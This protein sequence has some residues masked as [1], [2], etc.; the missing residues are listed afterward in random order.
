M[1][2]PLSWSRTRPG[3]PD[4]RPTS[5]GGEKDSAPQSQSSVGRRKRLGLLERK[6]HSSHRQR[7]FACFGAEHFEVL[8]HV[9][10]AE[11]CPVRLLAIK[12]EPVGS[13]CLGVKGH[14]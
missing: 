1:K 12:A 13:S 2:A 3:P 10:L 4:H 11:Q 14:H 5:R 8:V 9:T 7:T 6:A